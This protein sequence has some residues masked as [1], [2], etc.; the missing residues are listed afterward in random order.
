MKISDIMVSDL[1]TV[2]PN[3]TIPTVAKLMSQKGIN[4]IMIVNKSNPVGIATKSDF[5]ERLLS[6][7]KN[8]E[9]TKIK[10]IMSSP[11]VTISPDL[12]VLDALKLMKKTRFS[13]IPV[14]SGKKLVGIIALTDLM[15]FLSTFFSAQKL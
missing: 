2:N 3:E 6:K 14:M 13:Q 11:L 1:V 9:K 5:L 10:E 4:S 15:L 7:G 8:P 12:G